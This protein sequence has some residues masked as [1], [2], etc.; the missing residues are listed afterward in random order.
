M[1]GAIRVGIG[2]WV[3]EPWRGGTFYPEG[4]AQKRELEYASR[5]VTTI[6]INGTF[7]GSQKPASFRRWHDETPE[8]FVFSLKGP[9]YATNR[10]L[11]AGAGDSI[12]RFLGSGLLELGEKLGPINWQFAATKAYDPDDFAAFLD[13]LPAEREGR[14]LRHVVEVRHDSF[15]DPTF[16]ALLRARGIAAVV[17]DKPGYPLIAD[18]TAPFVYLRLQDAREAEAEGYGAA[19]LERW[20]ERA[21][22]WASGETRLDLELLAE[23]PDGRE[24]GPGDEAAGPREVFVYMIN[25]CKERAPA[26]ARGLLRRVAVAG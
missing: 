12:E 1:S 25:G 5:Q 22:R 9:R 10:K 6:E 23:P 21:R 2:G 16:V 15:R 18:V 4:L 11:L 20:A 3:Y 7:Y 19:A 17:A 8:G 26:A 14:P 13:L 24:A